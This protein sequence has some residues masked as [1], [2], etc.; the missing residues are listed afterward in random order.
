M[1]IVLRWIPTALSLGALAACHV[2]VRVPSFADGLTQ[3]SRA[4]IAGLPIAI[5]ATSSPTLATSS[6]A[7]GRN[8]SDAEGGAVGVPALDGTALRS[9][10]S[11]APSSGQMFL[12]ADPRLGFGQDP[13]PANKRQDPAESRWSDFLPLGRDEVLAAG[14][15]LPRAF[16]FGFT[17]TRLRRDIEVDEIRVG[18]DGAPPQSVGFLAVEADSVVDNVMGRLDAWIFPFWN[19]SVL[20]GWTWNESASQ[21]TASIPFPV[22][23]RDVVIDVPTSQEGPT[24]GAGTNLSAGYGQ[25]FVSGDAMWIRADMS[26]FAVINAFLGSVRSG[27]HGKVDGFPMRLWGG[28]THWDTATTIE[29]SVVLPDGTLRF[30]VDQGPVTPWSLQ[31]GG[32]LDFDPGYGVVFEYHMLHDV[33]MLACSAAIRF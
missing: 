23:P 28:A 4:P 19:V 22:N 20:G 12:F 10:G 32:S 16:G 17:Y 7:R 27:W 5:A 11:S 13:E 29:G 33:R 2:P 30:E 15:E 24:W 25:W 14:Y 3:G 1:P 8:G 18:I 9:D 26:D 31:V 6:P 21:V